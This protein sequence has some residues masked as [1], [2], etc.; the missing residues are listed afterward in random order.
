M[1]TDATSSVLENI[2]SAWSI[3]NSTIGQ[4]ENFASDAVRQSRAFIRPGFNQVSLSLPSASGVNNDVNSKITTIEASVD[5]TLNNTIPAAYQKLFTDLIN[6]GGEVASAFGTGTADAS[7]TMALVDGMSQAFGTLNFNGNVDSL[8]AFL[9]TG[10]LDGGTPEAPY[11]L[12][13][14]IENGINDRMLDRIDKEALKAEEEASSAYASRGFPAPP[15]MMAKRISEVQDKAQTDRSVAIKDTAIDQAKRGF[16]AGQ[17]YVKQFQD[18]QNMNATAFNTYLRTV[19]AARAGASDDVKALVNSVGDLQKSIVSLYA[20][21]M[22]ERDVLLKQAIAEGNLAVGQA[23]IEVSS[24]TKHVESAAGTA[25]AAAQAMGNLAA[26]AVSS[27]N[28]MSRIS[29]DTSTKK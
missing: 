8:S 22:D 19:V 4:A 5:R 20:Y 15:G 28:S 13:V 14:A 23:N 25:I 27:Q 10:M 16:D 26:A 9:S 29:A 21:T 1:A 6:Q 7:D 17:N 11:G 3:A 18:L 12:P 2:A 24:F